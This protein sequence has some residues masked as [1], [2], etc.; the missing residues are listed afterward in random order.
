[1][2][3]RRLSAKAPQSRVFV[4]SRSTR[5]LSLG[6]PFILMSNIVRE[7]PETLFANSPCTPRRV[8]QDPERL[9]HLSPRKENITPVKRRPN[10]SV[11]LGRPPKPGTVPR[12]RRLSDPADGERLPT[13]RR[14]HVASSIQPSSV[15]PSTSKSSALF[16]DLTCGSPS[17]ASMRD[18]L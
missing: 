4:V 7:T 14:T 11:R 10:P 9:L 13:I 8:R 15:T 3:R 12:K 2:E 6:S 16:V 1:M 5:R 18:P 17:R